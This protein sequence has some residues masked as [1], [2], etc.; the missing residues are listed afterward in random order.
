M[1]DNE[2]LTILSERAKVLKKVKQY[3]DEFLDPR[4]HIYINDITIPEILESLDITEEGYYSA[5]SIAPDE[6]S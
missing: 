4:K 2:K 3:I 6:D 1:A 5:L